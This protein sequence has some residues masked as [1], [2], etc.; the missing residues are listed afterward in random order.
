MTSLVCCLQDAPFVSATNHS[1]QKTLKFSNLCRA[2]VNPV[3]TEGGSLSKQ[4]LRPCQTYF[5]VFKR[6]RCGPNGRNN[7]CSHWLGKF[8]ICPGSLSNI[9]GNSRP[10]RV[11]ELSM[12]VWKSNFRQYGQMEKQRWEESEKRRAEERRSEKR[13]NEKKEDA[14]ARKGRKVTRHYAFPMI[15]CSGGSKSRLA[16]AAGRERS[17]VAR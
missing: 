16:K 1:G 3:I 12:E 10:Q 14:G 11:P 2:M 9:Y 7:K 13:N 15:C 8:S 6:R 4:T 17:H 5:G